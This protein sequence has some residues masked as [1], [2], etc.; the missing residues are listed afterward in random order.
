VEIEA[1]ADLGF[2]FQSKPLLFGGKALEFYCLRTAGDVDFLVAEEDY[3]QLARRYPGHHKT[4]GSD[5]GVALGM[6][7]FW[8]SFYGYDYAA[9]AVDAHELERFHVISLE[10]LLL[11][12]ALTIETA[13][14]ERDTRLIARRL[15]EERNVDR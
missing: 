6:L 15:R 8:A 4:L 9:L 3:Q 14:G 11:L 5:M 10:R 12:K 7:E 13:K 2:T 1:L